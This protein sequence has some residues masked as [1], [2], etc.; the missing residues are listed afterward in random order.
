LFGEKDLLLLSSCISITTTNGTTILQQTDS[1]HTI[2]SK[3]NKIVCEFSVLL[4]QSSAAIGSNITNAGG[5][6]SLF[7]SSSPII[8]IF[9]MLL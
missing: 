1:F 6:F 5:S 7:P 3:I 4:S 8:L 9:F 2:V